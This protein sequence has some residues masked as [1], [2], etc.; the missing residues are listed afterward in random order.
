MYPTLTDLI[1]DLIGVNIPLP[2]QTYGFFV[3]L[4]F[5]SGVFFISLELKRKEKEG[6][7][8]PIIKKMRIGEPAKI[9]ALLLSG[10]GGFILGFKIVEAVLNYSD[11]VANPQEFILSLRGSFIGGIIG[12]GI[13]IYFTWKDKEKEKLPKPKWVE[14][15]V[16][17]YELSG[18]FLIIAAVFGLIG[19]KLFHNF[20]NFG[21]L[22]NDPIGSLISF[23]GLTFYGA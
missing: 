6:I 7:L 4:A 14:K 10:I 22:L 1:Q 2:I 20:E 15:V 9:S 11:F 12:A 17:P 23:S 16:H 19:A 3:A 13:S 8:K 5:L 21:E 18:N